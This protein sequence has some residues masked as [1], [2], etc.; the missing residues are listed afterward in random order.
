MARIELDYASGFYVS[1]SPPLIDKRVVNCYPVIP[2]SAAASKRV[3]LGTP[4]IVEV[5]D[6]G[7]GSSRGAL[8]FNDGTPYR[9]IGN[10]LIS[11]SRSGDITSHGF[12]SGTSDVSMA[13]NG[14]NMAIQDPQGGSYF[15]TP[16]DGVLEDNKGGIV[17]KFWTS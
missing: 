8:V 9:V 11:V 16:R 10:E 1:Q 14:I 13:T 2:Q 12:I 7:S 15:F 4:G 5:A 6:F 17:L 3:L